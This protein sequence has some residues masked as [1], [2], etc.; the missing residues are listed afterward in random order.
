VHGDVEALRNFLILAGILDP[1]SSNEHP[2]WNKN[3]RD[4]IVVQ[5]GDI[6]DRYHTELECI[7]MLCKLSH[8]ALE[9]DSSVICL[10]GNHEIKNCIGA[11][12]YTTPKANQEFEDIFGGYLDT[13]LAERWRVQYANNEP[14]RWNV[15]E[16]GIGLL[17][18]NVLSN[19]KVA[20]VVGKSLFV[21]AGVT[22]EHLLYYN[23]SLEE[24]NAD[25]NRWITSLHHN[26]TSHD[27][28]YETIDHLLGSVQRRMNHAIDNL[29]HCVSG[30][31]GSASPIWMRD[32][33]MPANSCPGPPK[34]RMIEDALSQINGVERMVMGH[35]VQDNI[36][37][38][39]GGR[40]Y[41]ID[42]GVSRGVKGGVAEVLEIIHNG[43][44]E[45]CTIH[46]LRD[47][48]RIPAHE[49]Q[50]FDFDF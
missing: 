41:R 28:E 47:G 4:T 24:M 27:G 44:D 29:P 43:V 9:Y 18:Q 17:S 46:V 3:C 33:S 16:P 22:K 26:E 45:D 38:A 10:L 39:L 49:R 34:Q 8:Q 11:F 35:T 30:S 23:N 7:R 50:V 25:A 20:V 32:Y 5:T 48:M 42:T 21:H 37:V 31:V 15:C 6:L 14:T 19:M 12:E 13:S 40:A 36:N 1:R 2:I